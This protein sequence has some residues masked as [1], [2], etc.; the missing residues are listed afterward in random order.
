MDDRLRDCFANISLCRV[1]E[2][3]VV[4]FSIDI[5]ALLRWVYLYGIAT[6]LVKRR[7][8]AQQHKRTHSEFKT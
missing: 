4:I 6:T 2:N 8:P 5:A 1:M 7:S 3:P